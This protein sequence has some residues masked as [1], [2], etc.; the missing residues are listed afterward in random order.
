MTRVLQLRKAI[1][2]AG[3]TYIE[4]VYPWKVYLDLLATHPDWDGNGFGATHLRWGLA[5]ADARALPTVLMAT[6]AGYPL[7]K[8]VGF[9]GIHNVTVERLDGEGI[10]WYEAMARDYAQAPLGRVG[11]EQS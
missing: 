8:S 10:I 11:A 9:E 7:Y 6:P 2:D 3:Q 4:D 1:D 5:L